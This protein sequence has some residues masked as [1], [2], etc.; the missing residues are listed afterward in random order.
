MYVLEHITFSN[1][2]KLQKLQKKTA[3]HLLCL[4]VIGLQVRFVACKLRP[5]YS[6]LLVK[7]K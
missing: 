3:R 1:I 2:N 5:Y 4:L 7:Q 6:R